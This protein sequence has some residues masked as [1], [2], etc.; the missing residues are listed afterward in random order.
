L[1]IKPMISVLLA[2][3][4]NRW[5]SHLLKGRFIS[6]Y[7]MISTKIGTCAGIGD[8]HTIRTLWMPCWSQ[9]LVFD[10]GT[11]HWQLKSQH[12]LKR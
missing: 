3:S 5:Y 12:R 1:L 4:T 7:Q 8:I 11:P 10:L 6:D 9:K 2:T